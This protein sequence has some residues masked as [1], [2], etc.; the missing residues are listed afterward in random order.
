VTKFNAYV[1]DVRRFP[2]LIRQ[3]FRSATT[4]TPGPVHLR[5]RGKNGLSEEEEAV[6]EVLTEEQFS[7]YPP[8]RPE[9]E[10]EHVRKSARLLGA[11]KK[12][13]I[14]AG[15]GVRIS[16]AK[17]ELVEL[18]EKLQIPVAT[19]LNGKEVIPG[20]HPL[21]VGVVGTYSR[22][23]ANQLVCEAD[24]VFFVG[25]RTGGMTTHTWRVPKIGTP[26]IQLDINAEDLGRNYPLQAAILGDAKVSLR[27]LIDAADASTAAS[28][29]AWV[30]RSQK[31]V[32]DWRVEFSPLLNS[33]S[34]PVRPERICKEMTEH[35][36]S[37]AFV[38]SDTG[39][40]GM[41][42][43][44]CLD[45]NSPDQGYVRCAGHL[46]WGFPAALGAK[47]AL[48]KRPV[49]LFSGD[50]G[51]WYH[52]GELETAVRWNIN[53]I[54]VV[55]NNC[56]QNQ[57]TKSFAR[58]YGG[59]QRANSRQLWTFKDT[60]LSKVAESM[61]AYAIRV[62][63]PSDLKGALGKALSI[64]NTPVVVEVVSDIEALAPVAYVGE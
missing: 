11:A 33:D 18:A 24:L 22:R 7:H 44:G 9:P 45:L 3:A 27:K 62:E 23:S 13:I 2:D 26:A 15:G 58:V 60:N 17:R 25:T 63:R 32:G 61:G 52:I 46:G 8:F 12:P 20:N 47:C 51:F 40:S 49:V 29:K 4:G 55:N 41:W 64:K 16:G 43:G 50:A 57:E 56:S 28:R 10:M 21:S 36:P 42:T 34:S 30:E 54:I 37:D 6:L 39:H 1:D 31:V 35:L 59:Q 5:F 19:S 14:V 48:P 38:V 53:A